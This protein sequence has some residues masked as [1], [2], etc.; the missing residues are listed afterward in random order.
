[1]SD[2]ISKTEASENIAQKGIFI[3]QSRNLTPAYL[4]CKDTEKYLDTTQHPCGERKCCNYQLI[5][6]KPKYRQTKRAAQSSMDKAMSFLI[7]DKHPEDVVNSL[8]WITL[9]VVLQKSPSSSF[10]HSMLN[11]CGFIF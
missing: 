6:G 10:P 9:L 2:C 5:E 8:S 7:P 1:M 3:S 4:S 11:G